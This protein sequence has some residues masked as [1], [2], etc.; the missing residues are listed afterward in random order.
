MVFYYKI[1]ESHSTQIRLVAKKEV[2]NLFKILNANKLGGQVVGNMI[3]QLGE[4]FVKKFVTHFAS[5]QSNAVCYTAIG[6]MTNDRTLRFN[7]P[8][9]IYGTH[10]EVRYTCKVQRLEQPN[11]ITHIVM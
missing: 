7:L 10:K 4:A 3:A 6:L 1:L 2:H 9:P 11:L 8:A 5:R